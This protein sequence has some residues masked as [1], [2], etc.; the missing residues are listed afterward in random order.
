[1]IDFTHPLFSTERCGLLKL[2][3]ERTKKE[4]LSQFIMNLLSPGE[5]SG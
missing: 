4:W 5:L 1:M 2:L 3:P